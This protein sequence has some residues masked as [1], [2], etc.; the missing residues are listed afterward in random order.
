M[1]VRQIDVAHVI[2]RDAIAADGARREDLIASQTDAHFG[3]QR[4]LDQI[5]IWYDGHL[6]ARI[7]YLQVV[8]PM[9]SITEIEN[10]D[11]LRVVHDAVAHRLIFRDPGADDFYNCA[12][13]E[14]CPPD[15]RGHIAAI[16]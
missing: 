15:R 10:G 11:N 4:P 13:I 8:Q 9:R 1:N 6:S 3:L 5:A 12:R 14:L 7:D 2:D 16:A